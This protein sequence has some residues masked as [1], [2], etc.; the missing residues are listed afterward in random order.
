MVVRNTKSEIF[1]DPGPAPRD[2]HKNPNAMLKHHRIS[3]ARLHAIQ[4]CS[5]FR[6]SLE[7][8]ISREDKANK[9]TSN[10]QMPAW[11]RAPEILF[12]GVGSRGFSFGTGLTDPFLPPSPAFT[13]PWPALLSTTEAEAENRLGK[14]TFLSVSLRPPSVFVYALFELRGCF[15]LAGADASITCTL[16]IGAATCELFAHHVHQSLF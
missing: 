14:E 4:I 1:S 6:V 7:Y 8:M 9:R 2:K 16:I 13:S 3:L 10:G 11:E 12:L 5:I 15:E